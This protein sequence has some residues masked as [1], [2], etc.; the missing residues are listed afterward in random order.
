MMARITPFKSIKAFTMI[1]LII[2]IVILAII[3]ISASKLL[4]SAYQSGYTARDQSDVDW[5]FRVALERMARDMQ[6]IRSATSSDLT[7]SPTTEIEFTDIRGDTI[8][9]KITGS[10]LTRKENAGSDVEIADNVSNLSFSYHDAAGASTA[11]VTSVRYITV[12]FDVS[13]GEI[14]RS[15]QTTVFPRNV[16]Y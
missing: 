11:T 1:E 8:T 7:I 4:V 16:V 14:D 13:R 6:G 12:S 2:V 9:Y 5:Q 3:G 15:Y 10:S